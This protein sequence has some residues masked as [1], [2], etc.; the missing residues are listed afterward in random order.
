MRILII[1][2]ILSLL[3]SCNRTDKFKLLG[4]VKPKSAVEIETSDLWIGGELLD[5]DLCDYDAYKEYLGKLGAKKIPLQRG[6][7]KTEK[8][9]GV[10][11]LLK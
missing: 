10:L 2:Q 7:A 4:K 8:E 11:N 9:K 6:W 3:L 1:S 5:R